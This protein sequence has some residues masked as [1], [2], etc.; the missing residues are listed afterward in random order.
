MTNRTN[1][2][3]RRFLHGGAALAGT[4]TAASAAEAQT[5]DVLRTIHRLRTIHGDFSDKRVSDADVQTILDATVRAANASNTQSYSIIVS[6]DADKIQ[7]LTTYK[8]GCLLLY[9]ADY[10]RMID[11]ARHL[12]YDY[13]TDNA[14]AFVT[15]AMNTMLAAQTAVIAA[16]SLGIDSLLTNGI[17]RG[18]I[19]RLWSILDLPQKSCIPLI[20]LV[21]GYPRNE[22]THQRGRL[23]GTGIVHYEKYQRLQKADLEE[24][25]RLYDDKSLH[26]GTEDWDKRGH[27]HFLDWFHKEWARAG[28]KPTTSEGQLLRRLK[29]S[30]FI[31][32]QQA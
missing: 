19:E 10:T 9:C 4:L 30:G 29:K 28:S 3:R 1:A 32:A 23:R 24:I 26:I 6:R 31:D 5:N 7:K 11:T 22:P 20:A 18:D 25:V 12:G 2:S 17:H 14:E 15:S 8:A 21:L 16:K 27:K 13:Y